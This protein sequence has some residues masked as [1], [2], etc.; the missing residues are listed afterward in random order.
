MKI[1]R[2]LMTKLID[3]KNS[4]NRKPLI[5]KGVR[6]CGKTFLLQEFGK[7]NFKSIAY[8]NFEQNKDLASLFEGSYE[9]KIILQ[10]LSVVAGINIEPKN[11]LV[12]FDE[13][14]ACPRAINSLKYFCEQTPEY[15]VVSAGSLLGISLASEVGF[16]VGKVAFLELT[17]CTF[18]EYLQT[19]DEP[20]SKYCETLHIAE[21]PAV[22]TSKL[23]NHLR[24][25]IAL[26]GMPSVLKK[27]IESG[28]ILAADK[29]LDEILKSYELDF[30]K[31]APKTDIQKLYLIW[32][33]I[34]AQLARENAR[35]I[36]GEVRDGARAK[37]LENELGWLLNAG[38]AQ[39]VN[40]VKT[41]QTPLVS[42]E[43]RKLFKLYL[44]DTGVLRKLSKLPLNIVMTNSDIFGEFKGRLAENYVLQQ[45][46]ALNID[47]IC[48]W[49]SGAKAEIDFIMQSDNGIIPIEVKSGMNLKAKSLKTFRQTYSPKIS[50]RTSMQNLRFDDG[51]LNIPL[52]LVNQM[53]RLIELV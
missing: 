37:D 25:Y 5:L 3:W 13:I 35:F 50:I 29:I 22:F 2:D 12:I 18:K 42:Y 21:I 1:K 14:Q 15:A 53:P 34:P 31:H 40:N 43:E 38:L 11:T 49:T 47:P 44:S 8:F 16:P 51:L 27:F 33:S 46:V 10:N 7:Q 36:F 30:S 45:M 4:N 41:A 20:L 48:Y 6:Q 19:V 24:E 23:E 28:D 9:P 39:K 32:K 26:G 17:P 52:Y